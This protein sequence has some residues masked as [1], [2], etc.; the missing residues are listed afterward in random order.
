MY[1]EILDN[2]NAPN[3]FLF[4]AKSS[5]YDKIVINKL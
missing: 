3:L 4:C 5:N 2:E 1:E